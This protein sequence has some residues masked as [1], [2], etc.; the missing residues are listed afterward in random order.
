MKLGSGLPM[1]HMLLFGI[2]VVATVYVEEYYREFYHTVGMLTSLCTCC[3][4]EYTTQLLSQIHVGYRFLVRP[5]ANT[6]NMM[7]PKMCVVQG[8]FVFIQFIDLY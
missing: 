7:I 1:H 2:V 5:P 8:D 6:K 4:P 3:V